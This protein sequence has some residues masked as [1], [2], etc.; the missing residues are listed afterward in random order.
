MVNILNNFTKNRTGIPYTICHWDIE[1]Y[2]INQRQC[3]LFWIPNNLHLNFN[4]Q[5]EK[6][7]NFLG[8]HHTICI[9]SKPVLKIDQIFMIFRIFDWYIWLCDNDSANDL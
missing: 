4:F 2:L 5:I 1:L 8:K 3:I 6:I 9:F 7:A